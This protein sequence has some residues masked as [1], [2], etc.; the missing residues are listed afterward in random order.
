MSVN[1][2][3]RRTIRQFVDGQYSEGG[4]WQYM[5][6]PK[7]SSDALH[8]L[9]AFEVIQKDVINLFDYIEPDEVNKDTYSFRIH[10][11]M[12]RVCTEIE[13][14]F[15]AILRE[16]KYQKTKRLDISDYRKIEKSHFL[17]EY[18]VKA[19]V[20]RGD[21]KIF[22][23]FNDWLKDGKPTWYQAYNSAKHDRHSEFRKAN[24]D[25]LLNAVAG[26]L[27]VLSSQFLDGVF[28]STT[29]LSTSINVPIDKFEDGIG[30]YFLV[31]FP[32][33]IPAIARYDFNWQTLEGEVDPFQDFDY[34]Q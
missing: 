5:R 20:W 31:K 33:S 9:R 3:F 19:P 6:H 22:H 2:P 18:Q 29:S 8:Y 23:P 21:N 13:A 10:E 12:L 27:V 26:L 34:S 32:E 7:F 11:L 1:K 16:N 14:N 15:K 30:S 4:R 17:S 24:F 25:N 28:S